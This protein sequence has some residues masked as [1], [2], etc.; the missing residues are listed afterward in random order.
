MTT[1][2]ITTE[3]P[4][5]L[6]LLAYS[7]ERFPAWQ[8]A[9]QLP[10]FLAA[11]LFGQA[12]TDQ[13]PAL[14]AATWAGFAAFVAYTLMV[15]CIDD[16]KDAAHDAEHY[17]ER[18][19][20]RGLVTFTQLRVIAVLC[21]VV[22]VAV[23]IWIDGGLGRVTLWWVVIFVTNNLVQF[24]QVKWAAIGAWLESRRVLLALSVV[25]FWGFGS[26]WIAQMGG[27]DR[28][29]PAAVWWLV[30]LWCVAALL[31]EI[32][33]KSRT[34]DDDRPTVVDYTKTAG[35][36]TRSLGL[37]GTVAVLVVL[38]V[39]ATV[40]EV[41]VLHTAGADSRWAVVALGATALLPIGAAVRFLLKPDRFR[42][43]DVA[44]M[45]AGLW[46]IGQIVS[47]AALLAV[48]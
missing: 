46:L 21:L 39:L 26:V 12:I 32:A 3:S 13:E 47:V 11:F 44:E 33:R 27:G 31:L 29:V 48:I 16:N 2:A 42:V 7:N 14:R 23:S 15:R 5:A 6:R 35:S 40:L 34:P 20:Q 45:S 37:A 43:K 36:W 30:A 8:V 28:L 24:V 1:T 22:S 25:P 38:A 19:L 4:F 17:P 41:V 9:A 18:V 10:M